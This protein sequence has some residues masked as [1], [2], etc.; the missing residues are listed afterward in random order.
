M[1]KIFSLVIF[2]LT[3]VIGLTACYDDKGNYDY[4]TLPQISFDG[5]DGETIF[6]TQFT[7]LNLPVTIDFNGANESEYEYFW[8]LWSNGVGGYNEQK[9]I[10]QGKDLSYEVTDMP[11]SYTLLLTCQNKGTGVKSYRKYTLVVQGVITEAWMVLQEKEGKTDFDMIMS[12]YFSQRV[13]EDKVLHDVY[14]S[15]NNEQLQGRGVKIGSFYC[16]GRY[17]NVTILTDKSGVRL[18]ATTMQKVFDMETLM[19]DMND[20]KPQNYLFFPY[21]WSPGSRGYDAIISNGKYYEYSSLQGFTTY[22]EAITTNGLAYKA[23]P[24]APRWFDYYLGIVYDELGGRFLCYSKDN[25]GMSNFI[26]QEM[27]ET[28][29]S[30]VCN[31]RNMHSTLRY[32]DSGFKKYEW[33]LFKDWDTNEHVLY[34]FNFDT[35]NNVPKEKYV[36]KDCPELDNAS[37]FAIGDL[38]PV[39]FYATE[40]DVYQYDYAGKNTGK[41]VYSLTV[42]DEKITGMKIFKPCVDRFIPSHDF[43]NKI[44]VLST[45]NQTTKEGKI[46]MYHIDASNGAIDLASEKVFDGFGE[47][48]DM[49]YNY[50]K[51]GS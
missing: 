33:G 43:N 29:S 14:K 19:P 44:L 47:I 6:A 18:D 9:E 31:L 50:P 49:E 11:G 1:K 4:I 8:R 13:K 3:F 35:R 25:F 26:L 34:G 16:I 46:Y 38:G 51:W 7:T 39:F 10:Y 40:K 15:I 24:Y 41:K 28:A 5:A 27:P 17:Q 21:Y 2:I 37:F 20:W 36:V 12:P 45:Y 30:T 42:A 48:L 23:S 32:M 22:I